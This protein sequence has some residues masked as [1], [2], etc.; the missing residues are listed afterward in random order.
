MEELNVAIEELAAEGL[1]ISAENP[2]YLDLPAFTGSE[3]FANRANAAKQSIEAALEGKVVI[4]LIECVDS[5]AWYYAG[6]YAETGADA[7]Y[8]LYDVS[9]WGPDYGDPSTYLNTILPDYAGYM[10]K[11]MGM[12]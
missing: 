3:T 9:G 1:E 7:N 5:A 2:I 6:Y 10:T 4:N 8:D 12:F 11:C